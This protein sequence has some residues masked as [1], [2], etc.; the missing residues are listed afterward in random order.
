MS[1][2]ANTSVAATVANY[3]NDNWTA[4]Q[5]AGTAVPPASTYI[6]PQTQAFN[7]W[8]ASNQDKQFYLIGSG[9]TYKLASVSGK[10]A[11]LPDGAIAVDLNVAYGIESKEMSLTDW[12]LARAADEIR[13]SL[14]LGSTASAL[15][16]SPEVD[17]NT[18]FSSLSQADLQD[19]LRRLVT[20]S[21]DL[22]TAVDQ[23]SVADRLRVAATLGL[24]ASR[25][26]EAIEQQKLFGQEAATLDAASGSGDASFNDEVKAAL[27]LMV[28]T[29]TAE[30]AIAQAAFNA[31]PPSERGT[32][33]LSSV[34]QSVTLAL[35]DRLKAAADLAML[36]TSPQAMFGAAGVVQETSDANVLK[37]AAD[38]GRQAQIAAVRAVLV[39]ALKAPDLQNALV[40]AM[41]ASA[42]SLGTAEMSPQDQEAVYRTVAA[43]VVQTMLLDDKMLDEMAAR[44]VD[45]GNDLGRLLTNED[46]SASARESAVSESHA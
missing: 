9:A 33:T 42:E 25:L 44:A 5:Q 34:T 43:A 38:T 17:L 32:A 31:L 45:F 23:G 18:D 2:S 20:L 29:F 10:D 30:M 11:S 15:S 39:E 46:M 41:F 3:F 21:Q 40:D 26:A 4:L 12:I 8:K 36:A 13:R 6:A 37:T 22:K 16:S 35:A 19:L 14:A 27:D 24:S 28:E 1:L 7:D